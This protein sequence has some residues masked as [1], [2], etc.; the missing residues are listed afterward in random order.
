MSNTTQVSAVGVDT[1]GDLLFTGQSYAADYPV[2]GSGKPSGSPVY[3]QV[4][5]TKLNPAGD[6]ILYST[7]IPSGTF[8][9]ATGLAVGQD[10]SAY[11]AGITSD[12]NFPVTSQNLGGCTSICNAGF[13]AKFDTTGAMVYSTTLGSG[14]I[15]PHAITV[16]A[17]GMNMLPGSRQGQDCSPHRTPSN[18]AITGWS[19]RLAMELSTR[20]SI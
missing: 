4:V 17:T 13:V 8:N 9:S 5:L 15:L 3:E 12:P 2:A 7:Y 20:S 1:E 6:T 10:G 11:V 16:N 18:L 14:Q 19:V